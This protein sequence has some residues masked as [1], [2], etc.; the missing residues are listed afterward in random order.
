M[1]FVFH[2][3]VFPHYGLL[4]LYVCISHILPAVRNESFSC[5]LNASCIEILNAQVCVPPRHGVHPA[6][7]L[8][9]SDPRTSS[10]VCMCTL[11]CIFTRVCVW[12]RDR[13]RGL[14]YGS[15]LSLKKADYG[16][17]RGV[18]NTPHQHY[19]HS[20]FFHSS[21][22]MRPQSCVSSVSSCHLETEQSA[23]PLSLI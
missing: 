15:M 3:S 8:A 14:S 21:V 6:P 17:C 12:E 9:E 1:F 20:Q 22:W 18:R 13:Q 23:S 16:T 4:S 7:Q 2:V 10:Q 19:T 11:I 5:G